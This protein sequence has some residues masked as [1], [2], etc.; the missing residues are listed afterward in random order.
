M[1]INDREMYGM[2]KIIIGNIYENQNLT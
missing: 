1:D 2:S